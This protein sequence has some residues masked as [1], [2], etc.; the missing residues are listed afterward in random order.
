MKLETACVSCGTPLLKELSLVIKL[1]LEARAE[2]AP[3]MGFI[4]EPCETEMI[5]WLHNH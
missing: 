4:C 5:E 2:E 1:I 3:Y